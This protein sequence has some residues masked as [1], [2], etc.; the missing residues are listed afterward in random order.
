MN[1]KKS[2]FLADAISLHHVQFWNMQLQFYE[3]LWVVVSC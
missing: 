3:S 1:N 2:F